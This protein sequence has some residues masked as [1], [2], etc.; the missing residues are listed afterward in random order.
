MKTGICVGDAM[1]CKPVVL[2]PDIS[3][4]RCSQIMADKHVGSI[5]V[6]EKEKLIG[7]VT[8]QDI[9][10]KAVAGGLNCGAAPIKA[11]MS[12]KLITITPDKDMF[13]ALK[14]M[15]EKNVRHLP[16]TDKKGNLLGYIT[17]KDILKLQPQL[18]EL[19]AD[20]IE[21]KEQDR[22]IQFRRY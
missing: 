10:R 22:K 6:K 20:K 2:E 15:G 21:L 7:L 18:F 3:V 13:D 12:S 8:E 17:G 16:V 11:I 14:L 19:L 5:V 9:V 1:T 4:T